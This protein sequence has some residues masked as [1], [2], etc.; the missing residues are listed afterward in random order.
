MQCYSE[1]AMLVITTSYN[2]RMSSLELVSEG[3]RWTKR[4]PSLHS[5]WPTVKNH[6]YRRLYSQR[7][8]CAQNHRKSKRRKII[9]LLSSRSYFC[10]RI[11][12]NFRLFETGK[13]HW[14]RCY[15]IFAQFLSCIRG[16][17]CSSL[18]EPGCGVD[19]SSV[20]SRAAVLI[21]YSCSNKLLQ[22]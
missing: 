7:F 20:R 5:I 15:G 19:S 14:G 3:C 10:L 9:C 11:C 12:P 2:T 8:I 4:G 1:K 18:W 6:C 16:I 21:K 17:C 22:T 13:L